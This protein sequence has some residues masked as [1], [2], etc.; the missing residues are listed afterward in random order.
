[1]T[2]FALYVAPLRTTEKI[3]TAV[4]SAACPSSPT[5]RRNDESG[6][7]HLLDPGIRAFVQGFLKTVND[8][9]VE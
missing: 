8:H 2:A 3:V 7:D 6:S 4:M 5:R 9:L 1:M